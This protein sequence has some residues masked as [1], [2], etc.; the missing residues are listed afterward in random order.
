[1]VE[2]SAP[3][4]CG[5]RS[6]ARIA[7]PRQTTIGGDLSLVQRYVFRGEIMATLPSIEPRMWL[8]SL[9]RVGTI[10]PGAWSLIEPWTPRDQDF[11]LRVV[12]FS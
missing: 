3:T 8:N 4:R 12:T 5:S 10:S 2:A 9:S 7:S 11:S 6:Y 1:M